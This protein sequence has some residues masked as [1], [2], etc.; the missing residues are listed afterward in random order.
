MNLKWQEQNNGREHVLFDTETGKIFGRVTQLKETFYAN[1]NSSVIGEY[2]S[3]EFAKQA[4]LN[5]NTGRQEN[6]QISIRP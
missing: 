5:S 3:L 6:S 1:G 4:I 2:I